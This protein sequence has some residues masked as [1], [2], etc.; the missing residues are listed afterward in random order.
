MTSP[1][2]SPGQQWQWISEPPLSAGKRT[3]AG[4][5]EGEG[6]GGRG[7]RPVA[8]GLSDAGVVCVALLVRVLVGLHG[9][10]GQG[11]G[12]MY[13]DFEAQRHWM[14]V[15]VHLP[16]GDWYRQTRDND[17]QYWGLDYPPL[18]AAVSWVFG[19]IAQAGVCPALVALHASRGHESTTG[20]AFM[21]ASVLLLDVM[22]LVPALMAASRITQAQC[23]R[24]A[25]L[26]VPA[27][28]LVD[29]GHFQYNGTCI[30]LAL[31]AALALQ[32]RL[33]VLA[34]VL[35]CLS[36]NFKQMALYYAPV[37]FFAM[38]RDALAESTAWRTALHLA[39]LGVS[40]AATF[41]ALW[42]PFCIWRA[43][44]DSCPAALLQVLRR[45]FPFERGIFEDKVANL[46]YA[47]SVVVD[48]RELVQQ[49]TLVRCSLLLTLACLAPTAVALLGAR[50]RAS[51]PSLLL[52]LL[53][54][55]LAFFLASFQVHEK[56]LLLAL[57]PAVLLLRQDALVLGWFQVL[58]CFTMFPLLRRDGLVLCYFACVGLFVGAA[59]LCGD[60]AVVAAKGDVVRSDEARRPFGWTW[61][62]TVGR[63]KAAAVC[64][65]SA[66]MVALHAAEALVPP[67]ARFPHLYPALFSLYGAANLA[68]LFLY[69]LRLQSLQAGADR[70]AW[71]GKEA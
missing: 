21:R 34:C 44:G 32:R 17:L 37:F 28:L 59:G 7:N 57:V 3:G 45:Q 10:S 52:A 12:P 60:L 40:V 53:N 25:A 50:G 67:P 27:L 54:S 18:T 65:S 49:A 68:A 71:E 15:T 69:T 31:A 19:S 20:K 24:L 4:G 9:Y 58:G 48:Y 23:S 11:Q 47:L 26:L 55:S 16:L 56:S 51:T 64:L 8:G 42:A 35:F 66:G 30:G 36:L 29:H 14:E 2:S 41:A 6:G 38:L 62:P 39:K 70:N 5:G 61:A 63:L 1:P 33:D 46:W 43:P 13:G 22:V